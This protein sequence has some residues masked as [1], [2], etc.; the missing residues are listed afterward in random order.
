M[1][2]KDILKV[3]LSELFNKILY[4]E[5]KDLESRN[6]DLTM[7]EMHTLEAIDDVE[8]ATMNN[9]ANKLMITAGTLTTAIKKLETKGYVKRERDENDGRITRLKLTSKALY[10]LAIHEKFH[11]E[12]VSHIL[13]DLDENEEEVLMSALLKIQDFFLENLED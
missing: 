5:E 10:V 9:V 1:E 12:M 4:L 13:K 6:I 11:D 2:C 8:E 7:N 3:I